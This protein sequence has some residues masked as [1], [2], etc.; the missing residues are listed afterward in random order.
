M[1][2]AKEDCVVASFHLD[3][4]EG[5]GIPLTGSLGAGISFR[6]IEGTLVPYELDQLLLFYFD[7]HLYTV[8][9]YKIVGVERRINFPEPDYSSVLVVTFAGG[10]G[11]Y[12]SLLVVTFYDGQVINLQMIALDT[13]VLL[14][15]DDINQNGI[16]EIVLSDSFGAALNLCRACL[17]C[18]QRLAFWH[19][20][21]WQ[22]DQIG[23]FAE[24]Y[25]QEAQAA[26]ESI[27]HNGGVSEIARF[28][29]YSLMSGT[30]LSEV[31]QQTDSLV[32]EFELKMNSADFGEPTIE[33]DPAFL[34]NY[35]FERVISFSLGYR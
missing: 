6:H 26:K 32:S 29:Y 4:Q 25:E 3:P 16:Q 18:T 11:G 20:N 13:Y 19:E 27:T 2:L 1:L 31:F 34:V 17:V 35:L 14:R 28:G 33:I 21:R 30:P 23:Q 12:G 7:E 9:D 8:Y 24:F 22:V 10:S 15:F 5:H